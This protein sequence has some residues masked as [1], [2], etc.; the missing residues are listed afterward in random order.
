MDS[1][2]TPPAA[3]RRLSRRAFLKVASAAG[4]L[5]A[6]YPFEIGRHNLQV[7]KH[8]VLVPRLADTFRGMKVVQISDLHFE[9]FNEAFFLEHVVDVVTG[10]KPD[11]V[12]YTGDF[13]SYGPLPIDFGRS[14]GLWGG[15]VGAS[16]SMP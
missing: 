9:E 10:L 6:F 11:V 4:A 15:A 3:R 2:V 8:D 7:T 13:V 14:S 16:C 1:A 12:L 5:G